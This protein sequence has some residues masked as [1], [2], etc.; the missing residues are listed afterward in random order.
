[1]AIDPNDP[2]IQEPG[3][4][5]EDVV[6]EAVAGELRQQIGDSMGGVSVTVG[7]NNSDC[8]HCG[9]E[10]SLVDNPQFG[11]GHSRICIRCKR[12]S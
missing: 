10:D 7:P 3:Q 11:G 5:V 1:M 2:R 12:T 8:P 6:G 9:S 4:S